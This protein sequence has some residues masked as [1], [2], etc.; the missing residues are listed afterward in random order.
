MHSR[1]TRR[2]DSKDS[3]LFVL[4]LLS[5]DSLD[6]VLR[7]FS[8]SPFFFLSLARLLGLQ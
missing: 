5:V 3:I 1:M 6:D 7:F 4:I 2:P 8:L